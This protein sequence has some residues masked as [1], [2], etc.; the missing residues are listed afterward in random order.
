MKFVKRS[1]WEK[2]WTAVRARER[3]YLRKN[4]QKKPSALDRTLAE[5]VPA[6]LQSTL[7]SAFCKA[8]SLVFE[9]GAGVIQKTYTR[10]KR[11]A[12][13]AARRAAAAETGDRDT[14]RAFSKDAALSH[15]KSLALTGVE[16]VGLGLLGIGIPDIPLFTAVLLRSLYELADGYGFPHDSPNE[17]LFLLRLIDGALSYGTELQETNAALDRYIGLGRWD[18]GS[19]LDAQIARTARR[20]SGELLYMK[21]LQGIPL[22]GAVGGAYDAVYLHRVQTYARLKYHKRFLLQQKNQPAFY[23]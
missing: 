3:A 13:A 10:K 5:R 18:A 8:F 21:F 20:L 15:G 9:Q 2:E 12:G 14:L 11:T 19:T 7:E 6:T 22:A 17:K 16:G 23:R 1:D 4:A